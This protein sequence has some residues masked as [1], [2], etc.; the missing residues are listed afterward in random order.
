[1]LCSIIWFF[2]SCHFPFV[3][4]RVI[5]WSNC[6]SL[7]GESLSWSNCVSYT[8][9]LQGI[10]RTQENWYG[11]MCSIRD[12]TVRLVIPEWN[13]LTNSYFTTEVPLLAD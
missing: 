11:E 3:Y 13:H 10:T 7:W 6:V 2:F 9:L 4:C 12:Q 1:L 5:W 8:F